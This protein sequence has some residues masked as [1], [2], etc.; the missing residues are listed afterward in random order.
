MMGISGGLSGNVSV[1]ETFMA[2][3]FVTGVGPI[4]MALLL[5]EPGPITIMQLVSAEVDGRRY[6]LSQNTAVQESGWGDIKGQWPPRS[7]P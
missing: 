3:L 1:S 5:W 6:S 2:A 7:A 4:Q